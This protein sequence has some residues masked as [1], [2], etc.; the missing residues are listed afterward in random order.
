LTPINTHRCSIL[1]VDDD[2]DMQEV[3]RVALTAEGYAVA[4]ASTARD[5]ID[6][7]R[8]H[9][10]VCAILLD[11][12]LPDL[13]GAEFR[14]IQLRDRSLAW[15]PVVVISGALDGERL[16]REIGAAQFVRK[17]LDVDELRRAIS[18]VTSK[19]R[20]HGVRAAELAAGEPGPLSSG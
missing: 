5:A 1:F 11:L 20:L 19:N 8:S 12:L 7:L 17:P 3:V 18:F 6:Y 10:D 2:A 15:I 13:E 9:A 14:R 16:A 4:S